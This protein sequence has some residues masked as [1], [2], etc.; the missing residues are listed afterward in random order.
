MLT[1]MASA[2]A[3][4]YPYSRG[5]TFRLDTPGKYRLEI[6]V[7]DSNGVSGVTSA[8]VDVQTIGWPIKAAIAAIFLAS[9]ASGAW[10]LFQ[11]R[12]FWMGSA[13]RR[14]ARL[15]HL[16][17]RRLE[18]ENFV[19]GGI[20]FM[21]DTELH[22]TELDE[23]LTTS[24]HGTSRLM[25]R[26]NGPLHAPA[27][28]IYML[29]IVAHWLEHVLQIYQIYGLGWAPATAGGIL[30]VIYPQ[31]VESET[32]HFV[33]DFI[34]WAGIIV[35]RPGFH[36]RARTYWTIAMII[37]TWHYIEHVL[38]MGQYL[39]GYYLFGAPHQISILQL[40]FPR[41]E[42]HFVYNLLVFIPMVIAVHEYIKPKLEMLAALN[43]LSLDESTQ[44]SEQS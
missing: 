5:A 9:A 26:L 36:G 8:D 33:Y 39:T 28:W 34:Q 20:S 11:T 7:S 16:D 18:M 44:S 14:K 29:V 27:L 13:L 35:L 1:S 31:L 25:H 15:K 32:L 17:I 6:A 37:Q 22:D 43:A 42:L 40:W 24:R 12:A 19:R 2:P 10:L 38:L 4:I 21:H 41:A 23:E 30:G 3:D